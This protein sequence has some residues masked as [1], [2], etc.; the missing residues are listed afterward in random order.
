MNCTVSTELT[1]NLLAYQIDEFEA[2]VASAP[3][4][5]EGVVMLPFFN[6]ER[7]PNLPKAKGCLVGLDANNMRTENLCRAALEGATF[8]LRFGVEELRR[9]GLATDRVTLTGGGANSATWRQVVADVLDLPVTM[10]QQDE[11]AAYGA[12]LQAL[13]LLDGS[14]SM[15]QLVGE[16]LQADPSRCYEPNADAADFYRGAY[17]GYQ[18]AVGSIRDLYS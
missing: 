8:A 2:Q 1:R 14:T 18:T 12:A 7:T 13:S 9:L 3:R 15:E 10:T 6:G 4:G 5:A 11:G 17:L 16:H